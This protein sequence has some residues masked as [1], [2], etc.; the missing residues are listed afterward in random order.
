MRLEL[1]ERTQLACRILA[2]L[3]RTPT[4]LIPAKD[5]GRDL[6]ISP[7]YV[8]KILAP[9]IRER[10]VASVKG[11]K[12][13]YRIAVALDTL[14]VLDLI[15]LVEGRIDRSTCMHGDSRNPVT[16]PC[17]LHE[18]WVR[19]R[20]ALLHELEGTPLSLVGPSSREEGE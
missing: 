11:P 4:D 2:I 16:D 19:A 13:G 18:P 3:D 7:D 5:L 10:W 17:T 1:D 12:G 15:E 20:E 14:C 8:T 6:D 9:L